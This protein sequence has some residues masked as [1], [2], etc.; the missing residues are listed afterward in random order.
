MATVFPVNGIYHCKVYF[1]GQD[2]KRSLKT[3]NEEEARRVAAEVEETKIRI[4]QGFATVPEGVSV[5][6]YLFSGGRVVQRSGP[7]VLLGAMFDRFFGEMQPGT[8]E[9]A[10]VAGMRIHRGHLQRHLGARFDLTALGQPDLQ[11]YVASRASQK[12]RRGR[13]VSR[14]TIVHELSTLRALWRW[15]LAEK[16]VTREYPGRGLKLPKDCELP[17]FQT[18]AEIERQLPGTPE[19]GHADLWASVYLTKPEIEKLVSDI[20]EARGTCCALAMVAT[21]AHT[22]MRRAE[23]IRASLL[24]IK[25]GTILVQERKRKRGRRTTRRVPLS[26][27]LSGVLN[28]WMKVHPGGSVLFARQANVSLTRDAAHHQWKYAISKTRWPNLPGFHCLRHSFI[29]N[30]A[31]DGVDQRLIDG[32]VGHTSD[33]MRRRYRHLLPDVSRQAILDSFG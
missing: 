25:D 16:I 1:Q 3:G 19:A 23:L 28:D 21:A 2:F 33:E 17:P 13:K 18:I 27:M 11:K 7:R 32:Y 8:L 5:G 22:G 26:G 4:L 9:D 29:S 12:G 10:T 31:S 15:C 14:T 6:D 20:R 24:D 30:L